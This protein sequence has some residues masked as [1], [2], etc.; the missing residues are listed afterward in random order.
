MKP[1]FHLKTAVSLLFA[2]LL[3]LPG[4]G[5]DGSSSNSGDKCSNGAQDGDE[6][7]VDCG[8]SCDPCGLGGTCLVPGDC[9]SGFC[10]A[11]G[12]CACPD[13]YGDNGGTCADIDECA[14]NAD[15][16]DVNAT[17]ANTA[18]SFTC[19]CNDGY[20]GDG[21]TCSVDQDCSTGE[22]TCDTNATCTPQQGG[23]YCV[24]NTGFSGDG[25]TCADVNECT[26]NTDN[27][28]A[29]ATCTN[30]YGSFTCTCNGG[31]MGNGVNCADIN[32]CA[33]GAHNCDANATCANTAG[34]FTCACNDG[35]TGDGVSC[36]DLDECAEGTHNCDANA[37]CSNI[38]GTF[39]CA[40]NDGYTGDGLSCT[41]L[42]EC[43]EGTHNCDANATCDNTP[44]SFTCD[45][46][47]GYSGDGV[48][49]FDVNECGE[50]LH[51]CDTNATCTNTLGSYVCACN[52]GYAGDGFSCAD[53]DECAEGSDTCHTN[54]SCTNTVGA[55]TCAC[56]PGYTGDGFFCDDF[57]ECAEGT[58]TC[59]VNASCTNTVGSY[60]CTCDDGYSG[61][62]ST[63]LEIDECAEGTDT[64]DPHAICTNTEG[65]FYCTCPQHTIDLNGDGSLCQFH[66]SCKEIVEEEGAG[67]PS[68]QYRIDAGAGVVEVRCDMVSDGG[69]GYTMLRIDSSS[70][71]GNQDAYAAAC[72][73]VGMEIIVPRTRAHAQAIRTWNGGVPNLVNV[74]PNTAGEMGLSNWHGRCQGVPCRFWLSNSNNSDCLGNEPNGDNNVNY[75]IYKL[76]GSDASCDYGRWNDL[77]NTVNQQGY[78]ICS[79]NDAEPLPETSCL[80]TLNRGSVSNASSYGI[81]GF[82]QIDPDGSGGS[83]PFTTYCDQLSDGGG[84][85]LVMRAYND[86]FTY[87]STYWT[88]TSTLNPSNFNFTT[89]GLAKYSTFNTVPVSRIRTS[90]VTVFSTGYSLTLVGT[91]TSARALFSSAGRSYGTTL[92]NHFNDRAGVTLANPADARQW[93]CTNYLNHGINQR[94]YL[95]TVDLPGGGYCD[96]NGGA[97]FGQRVNASHAGTGNHAGQGWGAYSTVNVAPYTTQAGG[98]ALRELLWVK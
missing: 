93:G 31:F 55:F 79:T 27:C 46:N 48:T 81:T 29:N 73:A 40:C 85:T 38:D 49:C 74:F 58:H 64:C 24:C 71:G 72:A 61:D 6:T 70:L 42:D 86:N 52:G 96:W 82:Y 88:S 43:A 80:T 51:I 25:I 12:V 30:T 84:W 4:L 16:C 63:C 76:N 65:S 78:V 68:G 32:E 57:D 41:D 9:A 62:G 95:G 2:T 50:G 75:R 21:V 14:T 10:N 44:G 34:S 98:F 47:S 91:Y 37:T 56:D 39:T 7:G 11:M 28:D 83:A 3:V 5:C 59:D 90:D 18:G 53:L 13:G 45:C 77:N 54:A 92:V 23:S 36:A 97:R 67:L 33:T 69:V 26:T 66:G 94:D 89:A 19:A 17:C 35:Y 87:D 20:V 1:S 15:N 60:F 22:V 8:G